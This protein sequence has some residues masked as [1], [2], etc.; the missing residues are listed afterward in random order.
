MRPTTR[1]KVALIVLV[2]ALAAGTALR[3]HA[4]STKVSWHHDEAWSYVMSSGYMGDYFHAMNGGLTGRWVPA[5]QWQRLWHPRPG[6]PFVRIASDLAHHNIHPP[7]YF[8]MLYV[9]TRIFGVTITGGALLNLP[10]ALLAGLALFGLGRRALGDELEA[11]LVVL[12]W[13]LSPA[14]LSTSTIARQYDLMALFAVLLLW[15]VLRVIDGAVALRRRDYILL[16]AAVAVGMLTHYQFGFAVV[17]AALILLIALVARDRGRLKRAALAFAG[18]LAAAVVFNPLFYLAFHLQGTMRVAMTPLH[19][20]RKI[21]AARACVRIFLGVDGPW[22][23][24]VAH[25]LLAPV[26]ALGG[27]LRPSL[28]V[29]IV[30][31][32]A[33]AAVLAVSKWRGAA[34]AR[35][36]RAHGRPFWVVFFGLFCLAAIVAQNV[37]GQSQPDLLT[38]RYLA[39]AYPFLAFAPLLIARLFG[40]AEVPLMVAYCGLVLLPGALTSNLV[41]SAQFPI[42]YS[43]LGDASAIVTTAVQPGE[44][45]P[46]LSFAPPHSLV[47]ADHGKKLLAAPDRWL[48]RLGPRSYYVSVVQHDERLR[49]RN[50][51]VALLRKHFTVTRVLNRRWIT[52][53]ALTPL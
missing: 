15:Q 9:W 36:R 45:G 29:L 32:A 2:V 23:R 41:I 12:F 39:L 33:A 24:H 38:V 50:L 46:P 10:I 4:I 17:A 48:G 6:F 40:R 16:A 11:A 28:L 1:R 47:F 18:G 42:D 19:T 14:V 8:W 21:V 20:H 37:N 34:L 52:V 30:L 5:S 31:A 7:L 49:T 22:A 43:M 3:A 27:G 51:L 13:S 26:R 35:L 53:Y 25:A 44:L